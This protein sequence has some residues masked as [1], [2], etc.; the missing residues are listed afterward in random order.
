MTETQWLA[1]HFGQEFGRLKSR[2]LFLF[3]YALMLLGESFEAKSKYWN[4]VLH[5]F[6]DVRKE[7]KT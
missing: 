5:C 2:V 3:A 6:T 4:Y 7:L 1:I